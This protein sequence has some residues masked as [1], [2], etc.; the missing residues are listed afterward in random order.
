MHEGLIDNRPVGTTVNEAGCPVISVR[1]REGE[2][3]SVPIETDLCGED[4]GVLLTA[5]EDWCA[6]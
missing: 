5:N 2:T 1:G 3:T 6:E 4:P